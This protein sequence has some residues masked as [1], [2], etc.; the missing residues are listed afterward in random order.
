MNLTAKSFVLA[1]FLVLVYGLVHILDGL[2]GTYGPG[3]AWTAGHLAFL[4]ALALFVP[5]ILE[6][7]R[8]STHR[9]AAAGVA[10]FALI[11]V[12]A[13][14]VQ[15]GID[16]VVGF[17]AADRAEMGTLFDRVQEVPGVMPAVYTV[18]PAFFYVGLVVLVVMQAVAGRI[19]WWSPA[20]V[21][22]GVGV[23]V[24]SKDLLT[25]S[26]LINLAGLA[27]LGRETGRR[28]RVSLS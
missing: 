23:V 19:G 12:A 17:L 6:L 9:R 20:L 11:G 26:A 14:A 13:G 5:L 24:A 10:V 25:L 21:A 4:A 27:P 16:V 15:F 1:P 3:L 22:L 2:D 8:R 18:V 28:E 7:A